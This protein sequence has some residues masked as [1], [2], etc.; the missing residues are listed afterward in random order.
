M[1]VRLDICQASKATRIANA[2]VNYRIKLN[3]PGS[4]HKWPVIFVLLRKF[5]VDARCGRLQNHFIGLNDA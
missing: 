3:L 1:T 4:R 5:F 2:E